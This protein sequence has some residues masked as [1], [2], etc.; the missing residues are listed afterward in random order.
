MP[1]RNLVWIAVGAVVAAL[2]WQVPRLLIQRDELY[3]EL[4][5]LVE[6]RTQILKHYAEPVDRDA[7][8]HGALKGMLGTLDPYSEYYTPEAFER[9]D[10]MMEGQYQGIGIEVEEHETGEIVVVSPIEGS[11]AFLAGLRAEDRITKINGRK[12]VEMSLEE[13]VDLIKSG[14]A[15]TTVLL[16][17]FRPG[18]EETFDREVTRDVVTMPTV[19][20][21]ARTDKWDW[22]H[23]IDPTLRIGYVRI[24]SFERNTG[25]QL[26][27]ILHDLINTGEIRG[28]IIDVRD[29]PGGFLDVVV[30]IVDHFVPQGTIVT[31][32]G[33]NSAEEV[34]RATAEATYPSFPLAILVNAGSASASEILAGALRDHGRATLVGEKTFGKGS[35]QRLFPLADG[36]GAVKIT[37][38]YY[39]LPN[40]ERIHGE[41]IRPDIEVKLTDEERS[42]MLEAQRQVYSTA[43]IGT[44]QPSTSTAPTSGGTAIMIDGQLSAALEVL[45]S[46][47]SARTLP[48]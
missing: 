37:T 16:T 18:T 35:V 31:T 7:L 8:L 32:R 27:N 6:A 44:T 38:G 4:S 26:D 41:G 14:E 45:R 25:R 43:K 46:Q 2:L 28:L 21:W 13:G 5:P 12:T 17:I 47:L 48:E 9:F 1:K 30:A 34:F 20:G 42:A 33:R 23:M 36:R 3:A 11:P 39:Y 22:D 10:K 40:G 15:G 19:R 29:N 24:R